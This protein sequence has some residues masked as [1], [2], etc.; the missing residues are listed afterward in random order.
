MIS[1]TSG[2]EQGL[3]NALEENFP[4]VRRLGCFYHY[5]RNLRKNIKERV[6]IDEYIDD[7]DN[8]LTEGKIKENIENF[9]KDI[10]MIP[11]EIQNN[12]NIIE[13]IYNKYKLDYFIKF[14]NYF[15]SKWEPIIKKRILNYAYATKGQRSNSFI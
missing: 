4:N 7:K 5:S 15:S 3:A 6:N 13:N 2:F 8:N 14:K 10:L 9:I 12:E 1:Y 11:F